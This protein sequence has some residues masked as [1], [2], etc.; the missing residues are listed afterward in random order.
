[1]IIILHAHWEG[2]TLVPVTNQLVLAQAL[3]ISAIHAHMD[4]EIGLP[5]KGARKSG[6]SSRSARRKWRWVITNLALLAF[7]YDTITKYWSANVPR[8]LEKAPN[9]EDVFFSISALAS[10]YPAGIFTGTL[11]AFVTPN[12]F[13]EVNWP[14]GTQKPDNTIF[15]QLG[16]QLVDGLIDDFRRRCRLA[17]NI[18]PFRKFFSRLTD[19]FDVA[20]VTTNYDDLIYR[21]LPG[22]ETGFDPDNG[23]FRQRKILA[24]SSWPCLLYL[25]G[26][27]HFDMDLID[28]NLH[29]VIWKEDLNGQFH[30]N[31]FGRDTVR[32][33]E[34]HE[35]PTSSIIAG[36]GKAEQIQRLPYRTYYSELDRLVYE[37]DAVLF[38]GFSLA[39]AHVR[40]AFADY[41]DERDRSV[42]F[43]DYANDGTML[44]N[45]DFAHGG[46]GPARAMRV[47]RTPNPSVK[48][49]GYSFPNTV[50]RL[51]EAR[52]FARCTEPTRRLSIWYN[53]M[54]EACDN[55][56]K[57]VNEL[58][59]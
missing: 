37:S 34:G 9:F 28:G 33:T 22:V 46:S 59:K 42:V 49:L 23:L 47:F 58:A 29:G 14:L 44:A 4:S 48:W 16:M 40:H 32:T 7:L 1:M 25:H 11:G 57:I 24:R 19:E 8:H 15:A 39:D 27:V 12:C 5:G 41:R 10:V 38:L 52:D 43:I 35:F 20:V 6:A 54:L 55:A 26:S 50:D 13:P 51:K 18:E 17:P 30:Q 2:G 3:Q 45:F 56:D 53:G 21:S 36:Y 31:A